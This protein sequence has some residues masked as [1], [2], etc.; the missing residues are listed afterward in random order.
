MKYLDPTTG[1]WHIDITD[2]LLPLQD[3][4]VFVQLHPLKILRPIKDNEDE[5]LP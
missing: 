3:D 4:D 5:S 2:E 1:K